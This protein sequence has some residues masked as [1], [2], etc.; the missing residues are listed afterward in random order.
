M[1]R[2]NWGDMAR[3]Q[4][5]LPPAPVASAF[6]A[7]VNPLVERIISNIHESRTLAAMRD[8]LLPK[9]ISSELRVKNADPFQE[10]VGT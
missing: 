7:H 8:A 9:L 4:I 5:A 3:Y 6:T 1:P 10:A 2:T